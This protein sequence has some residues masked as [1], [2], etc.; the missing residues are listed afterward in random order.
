MTVRTS[1]GGSG[2]VQRKLRQL[3]ELPVAELDRVGVKTNQELAALGI[4]TVLDVLTHYP[5]RYID[6]TR[7]RPITELEVGEKVS[8]LAR[9][10]RVRQASS[11]YG[12][13]RRRGPSRVELEIA[14]DSG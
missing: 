1:T 4:E 9:V 2:A 10:S 8:V 14:D 3:A 13:G 6:G 12:R 5:R 11:G 7:L